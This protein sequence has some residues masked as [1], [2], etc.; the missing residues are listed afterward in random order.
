MKSLFLGVI[1]SGVLFAQV[2]HAGKSECIIQTT[3]NGPQLN[4]A[5]D[6]AGGL[7]PINYDTICNKLKIADAKL[8]VQSD[9]II[10][11]IGNG[12]TVGWVMVGIAE[13]NGLLQTYINGYQ[14]TD[15][16][17]IPSSG[18]EKRILLRNLNVALEN[19]TG[20]DK[21]IDKLNDLR[22]LNAQQVNKSSQGK[23]K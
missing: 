21:A 9:S 6:Q 16:S 13:K 8:I 10:S 4:V 19:W 12:V 3:I 14:L 1:L 2:A 22:K 18:E 17:T 7:D 11:T 15:V 20:I 5:I 23:Q